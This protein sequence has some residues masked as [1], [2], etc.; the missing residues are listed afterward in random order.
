[1][2]QPLALLLYE[3]LLPGS[4]LVNRLQ[5]L[6]WRVQTINDGAALTRAAEKHKPLLVVADLVSSRQSVCAGLMSLRQNENTAHLPV[7][8]FATEE[9]LHAPAV[10]AGANLVASDTAILQHLDQF[11]DQVLSD[12]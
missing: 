3:R 9:A 7:I 1:M 5:D 10:A 2:T 4:Q 11:L 8:A 6:G 12:F